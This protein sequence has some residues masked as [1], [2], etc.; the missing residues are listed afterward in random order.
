VVEIE[1]RHSPFRE[2]HE[3]P[4]WL[5]A[6]SATVGF[7]ITLSS[8][9]K[10]LKEQGGVAVFMKVAAGALQSVASIGDAIRLLSFTNNA[11][12]FGRG[13]GSALKVAETLG[14]LGGAIEAFASAREGYVLLFGHDK[15]KP[16]EID[17][18]LEAG[19][20]V[21]VSALRL[22]G[23]VL[24]S[25]VVPGVASVASFAGNAA[26]ATNVL[27]GEAAATAASGAEVLASVA[28]V[29]LAVTG[30]IVLGVDV[31]LYSVRGPQ[32][33]MLASRDALTSALLREFGPKSRPAG[34]ISRTADA[35]ENFDRSIQL[36][37][38]CT[39]VDPQ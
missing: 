29:W 14:P 6:F 20:A 38:G 23:V 27:Q 18:A 5:Q 11:L 13:A 16:N 19:N 21:V 32:D 24:L 26:V 22:K 31:Y 3:V 7:A 35:M 4:V 15:N 1:G 2:V 12:P 33:A 17:E 37:L 30:L 34:R 25:N 10:D 28:T 8:I 9:S 39:G 36:A